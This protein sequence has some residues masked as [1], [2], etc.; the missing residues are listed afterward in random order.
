MT[1]VFDCVAI[2][3]QFRADWGYDRF[4]SAIRIINRERLQL[5]KNPRDGRQ[6]FKA[7][8]YKKLYRKQ[9]GICPL[10]NLA[11]VMPA[12][13]P[14]P[15]EI[16]HLNPNREDFND[17]SNLQLTH[18]SCNRKKG[19]KSLQQQSK[20]NGRTFVHIMSASE[21]SESEDMPEERPA[22]LRKIMD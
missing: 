12:H 19:A 13:F 3:K 20:S 14:G 16:D 9:N 4:D 17:P 8:D 22:F 1:T 2:L 18:E 21:V 10:C 15:L 6:R 11:M 7:H 5:G